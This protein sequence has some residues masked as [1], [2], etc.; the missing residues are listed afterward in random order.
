MKTEEVKMINKHKLPASV[1]ILSQ[2]YKIFYED[3][4]ENVRLKNGDGYLEPYSKEI[5]ID[6]SIFEQDNN[7]PLQLKQLDIYGRKVIR[8]E[9][10]HAFIIESGLWECCSWA[11]N[12]EL[13]D[14]IARQFPKIADCFNKIGINQ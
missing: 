11:Q 10:I 7:D 2:E 1:N 5:H 4:E 3:E 6:K 14:W 12:E 13:T 8:H 9:I